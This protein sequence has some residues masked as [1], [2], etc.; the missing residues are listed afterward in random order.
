M[1]YLRGECVNLLHL[2]LRVGLRGSVDFCAM[3]LSVSIYNVTGVKIDPPNSKYSGDSLDMKAVRKD[4]H[5][6]APC[7]SLRPPEAFR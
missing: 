1:S 5:A 7:V 4:S 2:W 3:C 6:F